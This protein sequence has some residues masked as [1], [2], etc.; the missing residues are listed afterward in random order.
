VGIKPGAACIATLDPAL[1]ARNDLIV[2]NT[3]SN[4]LSILRLNTSNPSAPT[5]D[6]MASPSTDPE[7]VD[8]AAADFTGHGNAA[9]II[10]VA[11]DG[12]PTTSTGSLMMMGNM[13]PAGGGLA[14]V[15]RTVPLNP[16]T[17][18]GHV[19]PFN[20]DNDKDL[21]MVVST[22]T[23]SG[24]GTSGGGASIA[25]FTNGHDPGAPAPVPDFA[26]L[27]TG[28]PPP[29]T[30]VVVPVG[31]GAAGA[32]QVLAGRMAHTSM[33]V[34]AGKHEDV[35]TVNTQGNSVSVVIN[36]TADQDAPTFAP[37][38]DYHF[39]A[40]GPPGV[41]SATAPLSAALVDLDNNQALDLAVVATSGGSRV[42]KVLRNDST[43]G[44]TTGVH[45][46]L[47]Q[48][49]D[50]TVSLPDGTQPIAVV[51]ADVDATGQ[52][53]LVTINVPCTGCRQPIPPSVQTIPNAL[54]SPAQLLGACCSGSSCIVVQPVDCAGAHQRFAGSGAACN[55]PGVP[56]TPCCMGDFEQNGGLSVTGDIFGY[57]NAW[58]AGNL[59]ADTNS[60]GHLAVQDI[61]EFLN[62]WFAGC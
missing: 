15:P 40:A 10:V 31:D 5:M 57:L 62:A 24:G 47:A 6:L 1:N 22:R 35:L 36:T 48:M 4:T 58:F 9:T 26:D 28:N 50:S 32:G 16:G 8:V 61:F 54:P 39:D 56:N 17:K 20:P 21:D 18:P 38:V 7:P 30:P 51:A 33:S 23:S 12:G 60:D 52:S 45:V 59:S 44:A 25:V 11:C 49:P 34:P 3:G 42:V 19:L 27:F 13:T 46:V 53:D 55:A 41:T 37:A 29:L 43:T 14:F 2:A